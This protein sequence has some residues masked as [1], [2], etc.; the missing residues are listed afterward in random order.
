MTNSLPRPRGL[1]K[2]KMRD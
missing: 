1:G 2:L